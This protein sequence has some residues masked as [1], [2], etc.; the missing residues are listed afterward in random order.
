MFQLTSS[1]LCERESCKLQRPRALN[2]ETYMGGSQNDGLFLGPYYN[3]ASYIC[4]TQIGTIILTT[5]HITPKA[6]VNPTP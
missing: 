4:G 5:T 3:T 6:S 2:P 1:Q